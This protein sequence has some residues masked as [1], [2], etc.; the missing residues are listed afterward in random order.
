VDP[1][2]T[3]VAVPTAGVAGKSRCSPTRSDGRTG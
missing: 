3:G 2:T 1:G